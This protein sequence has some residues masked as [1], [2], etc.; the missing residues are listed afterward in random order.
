MLRWA[1]NYSRKY[2]LNLVEAIFAA[3]DEQSVSVIG[4]EAVELVIPRVAAQTKEH[5]HQRAIVAEEVE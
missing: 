2:P 4:A 3:L 1:R 5:K